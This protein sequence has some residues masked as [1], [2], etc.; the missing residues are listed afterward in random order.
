MSIECNVPPNYIHLYSIFMNSMQ[1]QRR[2]SAKYQFV[3]FLKTP[4]FQLVY[5]SYRRVSQ[6]A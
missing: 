4:D 6:V 1:F 3:N 2:P 5:A